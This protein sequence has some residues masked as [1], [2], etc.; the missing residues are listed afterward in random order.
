MDLLLFEIQTCLFEKNV[1]KNVE[2]VDENVENDCLYSA[3]LFD[4]GQVLTSR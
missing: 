2:N 4:S 3:L 1:D